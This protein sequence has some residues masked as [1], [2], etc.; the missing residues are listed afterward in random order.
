MANVPAPPAQA[1]QEQTSKHEELLWAE[2]LE[3]K[4]P[5]TFYYALKLATT[6]NENSFV[7][8]RRTCSCIVVLNHAA[9]FGSSKR[10]VETG[11]LSAG[12]WHYF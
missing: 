2:M 12:Q 5:G 6:G 11:G 4:P 8:Q 10:S 1:T 3:S 7:F 9:E